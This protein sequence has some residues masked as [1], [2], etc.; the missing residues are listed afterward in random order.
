[1]KSSNKML[2]QFHFRMRFSH[3]F[4]RF[5][6]CKSLSFAFEAQR[7]RGEERIH[8]QSHSHMVHAQWEEMY[9]VPTELE[10]QNYLF[11]ALELGRSFF[12]SID[13]FPPP[14]S[15]LSEQRAPAAP[16]LPLRCR[17][18]H[19]L[20]KRSLVVNTINYKP[21]MEKEFYVNIF[22]HYLFSPIKNI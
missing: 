18:I 21:R 4:I 8:R 11:M 5:V 22:F 10:Q 7:G 13:F 9:G 17:T 2:C 16:L 14:V 12:C 19:L 3:F 20:S 6:L 1:M 15:R